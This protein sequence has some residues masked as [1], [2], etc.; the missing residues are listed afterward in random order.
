MN[1]WNDNQYIVHPNNIYCPGH[2]NWSSHCFNKKA[3][4]HKNDKGIAFIA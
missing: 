4:P 3:D 1:F 2:D